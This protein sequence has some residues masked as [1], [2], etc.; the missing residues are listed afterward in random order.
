[1]LCKF[2]FIYER[3]SMKLFNNNN[4]NSKN[5]DEILQLQN[6]FNAVLNDINKIYNDNET[7]QLSMFIP[8]LNYLENFT[9]NIKK[10]VHSQIQNENDIISKQVIEQQDISLDM[11][12]KQINS[13]KE[14]INVSVNTIDVQEKQMSSL[15]A[16][17]II[18][19]I[20]SNL[21]KIQENNKR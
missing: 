6:K 8:R 15:K 5:A 11:L 3:A 10:K 13:L 17:C 2:Q 19:S 9:N 12:I 20:Q 7:K 1:M 21:E 18:Q 16:I 4:E 14:T